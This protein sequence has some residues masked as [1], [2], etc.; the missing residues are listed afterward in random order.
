MFCHH[1]FIYKPPR[2]IIE[3]TKVHLTHSG[4]IERAKRFPMR[5]PNQKQMQDLLVCFSE[6]GGWYMKKVWSSH[7]WTNQ[8][9]NVERVCNNLT[10]R[11]SLI[12]LSYRE[13]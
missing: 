13:N 4:G 7:I 1:L 2:K 5:K 10:H 11:P 8:N 9:E 12:H 3:I 6:G